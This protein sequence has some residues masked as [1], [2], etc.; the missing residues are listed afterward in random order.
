LTIINAYQF[1]RGKAGGETYPGWVGQY[2]RINL[3]A[4]Q[5]KAADAM[6][7]LMERERKHTTTYEAS[8]EFLLWSESRCAVHRQGWFRLLR[9]TWQSLETVFCFFCG[10]EYF[11]LGA[12][13]YDCFAV[14]C[15]HLSYPAIMNRRVFMKW[16]ICSWAMGFILG[17]VQ[18]SWVSDFPFCGPIEMSRISLKLQQC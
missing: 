13:T 10:T 18:P 12:V 14:V 3:N 8:L 1:T 4:A 6:W 2:P 17:T 5:R 9:N 7:L 11:L 16:V 15:S